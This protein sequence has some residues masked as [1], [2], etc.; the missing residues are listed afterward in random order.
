MSVTGTPGTSWGPRIHG[1]F[2]ELLQGYVGERETWRHFLVTAPVTEK[3]ARA[4]VEFG[5]GGEPTVDPPDRTLALRMLAA[6]CDRAGLDA[7]GARLTIESTIPVGRGMASSTAD[8]MATARALQ[9]AFPGRIDEA[10]IRACAREIEYGDEVLSFGISS[11]HQREHERVRTYETDLRLLVLGIDEGYEV[12]TD[13]LHEQLTEVEIHAL[14][15][16]RL[17]DEIDT[18]LRESD[19][20]AVGRVATRSAELFNDV[21]PK[22]TWSMMTEIGAAS[23]SLGIVAAHSGSVIGLLFTGHDPD[24]ARKIVSASR[25]LAAEQFPVNLFSIADGGPGGSGRQHRS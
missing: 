5:R 1:T 19:P 6:L 9:L 17:W 20:A 12:S 7:A 22:K 21:N 2:G 14:E 13:L 15:Y 8:V 10:D 4:R 23:E 24:H 25:A 3:W 16:A 18:A 11:C